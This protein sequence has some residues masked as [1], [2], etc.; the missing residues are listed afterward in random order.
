MCLFGLSTF[1]NLNNKKDIDIPP[2]FQFIRTKCLIWRIAI[3]HDNHS[4][5]TSFRNFTTW[6]RSTGDV[7]INKQVF[8]PFWWN[9][10]KCLLSVATFFLHLK[11]YIYLLEKT[12]IFDIWLL[13]KRASAKKSSTEGSSGKAKKCYLG[14][15]QNHKLFKSS[16]THRI[17]QNE[18]PLTTRI[19]NKKPMNL[20]IMWKNAKKWNNISTPFQPNDQGRHSATPWTAP[21]SN[22]QGRPPEHRWNRRHPP[23]GGKLRVGQYR[24]YTCMT[25]TCCYP[26]SDETYYYYYCNGIFLGVGWS[27]FLQGRR[28]MVI[29]IIIQDK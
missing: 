5:L 21:T 13:Q 10:P 12:I 27:Y 2:K 4:E 7:A 23:V 11:L 18:P 3:C 20:Y 9:L 15:W 24:W 29:D 25:W 26:R 22:H 1:V 16:W 28:R 6:G 8:Y 14:K 19:N 17:H